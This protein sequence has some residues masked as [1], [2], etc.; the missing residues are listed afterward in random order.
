MRAETPIPLYTWKSELSRAFPSWENA[1]T[2]NAPLWHSELYVMEVKRHILVSMCLWLLSLLFDHC[3]SK[4]S[5]SELRC[6]PYAATDIIE[7]NLKYLRRLK[8]LELPAL[9]DFINNFSE[10]VFRMLA[11]TEKRRIA[12]PVLLNPAR[13]SSYLNTVSLPTCRT[14]RRLSNCFPYQMS[15][16]NNISQL[17][18][19]LFCSDAVSSH[20]DTRSGTILNSERE[21]ELNWILKSVN[22]KGSDL[23]LSYLFYCSSEGGM[24]LAF[25]WSLACQDT[26]AQIFIS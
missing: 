26:Y 5:K 10:Y 23:K 2:I 12:E 6:L 1:L 18:I 4:S 24:T 9:C 14:C 20:A 8:F 25:L 13:A 16:F 22:L 3:L 15:A 11:S 19:S 21:S 17:L 7:P